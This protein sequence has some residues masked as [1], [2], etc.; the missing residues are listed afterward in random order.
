MPTFVFADHPVYYAAQG[1]GAA[2]TPLLLIHGVGGAY[3][4][5]PPHLRRLT[6][7]P[8]YA[9][10][11]PGHGR[12]RGPGLA[13]LAD[14]TRLI[15]GWADSLG[16]ETCVLAGHSLGSALALSWALE[17]PARVAALVLVGAGPRLR[18]NTALLDLLQSD[19]AAATARIAHLSY[20]PTVSADQ[21]E[22]YLRHLRTVDPTV[23]YNAFAACN[24]FDATARLAEVT[25]PTLILAGANDRMTPPALA[26]ELQAGIPSA[27]L[28]ILPNT[29]HMIPI[30]Q[31]QATRDAIA[32]FLAP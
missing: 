10:D 16:F 1:A 11:L 13:T 17:Q 25:M 2:G 30:E 27:M 26:S 7:R 5:W 12:S 8:V 9:I 14:F 31:P 6:G 22:V 15:D 24:E 20:G 18:V 32:A 29:G 4:H 23:L 19:F 28:Q 21:R 3:L